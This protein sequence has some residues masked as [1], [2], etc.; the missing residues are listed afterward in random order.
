MS[1]GR[2]DPAGVVQGLQS[3]TA[4]GAYAVRAEAF[5]KSG[6]AARERRA[7]LGGVTRDP[8]RRS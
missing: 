5:R 4:R 2:T 8:I 3:S 7:G 6:Q 1:F